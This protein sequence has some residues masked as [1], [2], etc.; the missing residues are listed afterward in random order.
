VDQ[1]IDNGKMALSSTL[2]KYSTLG[3]ST[4]SSKQ[5]WCNIHHPIDSVITSLQHLWQNLF[6]VMLHLHCVSEKSQ[7]CFCHN[8]VK[9]LLTLI[10]FR[11]LMAKTMKLCKVHSFSTSTNL[12]QCTTVWN[13]DAPNCC[14]MLSC[15]LKLTL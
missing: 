12:C 9:F 14:I 4:K 13:I 3:L 8:F 1:N 10:I 6:K 5:P 7:K 15:C 11:M 2:P